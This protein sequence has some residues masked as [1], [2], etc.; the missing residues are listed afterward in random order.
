M[1]LQITA[2]GVSL[3]T[4]L[5]T[6]YS[7]RTPVRGMIFDYDVIEQR[8]D[9]FV[10]LHKVLFNS[11]AGNLPMSCIHIVAQGRDKADVLRRTLLPGP[12]EQ[13]IVLSNTFGMCEPFQPG[14][15]ATLSWVRFVCVVVVCVFVFLEFI[16]WEH[17]H[18]R[19]KNVL[20]LRKSDSNFTLQERIHVITT[21]DGV[22]KEV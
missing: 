15:N 3:M 8:T 17:E 19:K 22:E 20:P 16:A 7:T 21:D 6:V 14:R 2:V 10:G 9:R 18:E 5:W 13:E 11:S 1:L 4:I 12:I